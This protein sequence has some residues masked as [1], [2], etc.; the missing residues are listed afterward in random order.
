[1]KQIKR[2]T[3]SPEWQALQNQETDLKVRLNEIEAEVQAA[4]AKQGTTDGADRLSREVVAYLNGEP[5]GP[6]RN[7]QE[8]LDDLFYRRKIAQR[9][10]Q[11]HQQRM[12][13]VETRL[14]REICKALRPEYQKLVRA[15]ADAAIALDAAM[16]AE[17]DFRDE[18][19]MGGVQYAGSL[20]PVVFHGVGRMSEDNSRINRFFKDARQGGYIQ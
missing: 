11:L 1:M 19:Y 15:V 17:K 10:L 20:T 5:T 9:A 14:S 8:A 18:L 16:Q 3:D 12:K 6:A 7:N 2:L 4:I 13:E